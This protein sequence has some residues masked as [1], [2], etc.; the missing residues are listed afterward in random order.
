MFENLPTFPSMQGYAATPINTSY[1]NSLNAP[2]SFMNSWQNSP[3]ADMSAGGMNMGGIAMPQLG[4]MNNVNMT[5]QQGLFGGLGDSLSS[6][7]HDT[8]WATSL[9]NKT[10]M[11]TQGLFDMGLG[12]AQGLLGAYLG[13]QNLGI[14]KD[15]LSQN[16]RAFDLNFNAQRNLTNSRLQD[17]QAARVAANPT[18][19]QSVADYMKTNGI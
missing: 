4:M 18:A 8:P 5:P 1:Y 13:F 7:F 14:A 2:S 12:A 16:K 11:K 9:N 19:Y 10:G 3:V 6:F 15:T 17:R